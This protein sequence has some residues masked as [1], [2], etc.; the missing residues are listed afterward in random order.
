M[1]MGLFRKI[2]KTKGADKKKD[3]AAMNKALDMVNKI[4]LQSIL[5]VINGIKKKEPP[6]KLASQTAQ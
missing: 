1:K 3:D 6:P 5:N 4:K 2:G